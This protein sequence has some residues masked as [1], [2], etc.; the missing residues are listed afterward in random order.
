MSQFIL[1]ERVAGI[2]YYHPYRIDSLALP[3]IAQGAFHKLPY[4]H[5]TA[6]SVFLF[7]IE[8][9]SLFCCMSENGS[10]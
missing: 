7:F 2:I 1:V 3:V 10:C 4:G 8:V 9:S 5:V 6:R